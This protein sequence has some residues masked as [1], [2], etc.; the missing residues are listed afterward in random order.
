MKIIIENVTK[1][2]PSKFQLYLSLFCYF[3]MVLSAGYMLVAAHQENWPKAI[4]Y[5][6]ITIINYL[7]AKN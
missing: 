6:L 2:S 4:F 1:E 5:A 3:G 7:S